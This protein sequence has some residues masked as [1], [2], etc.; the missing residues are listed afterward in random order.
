MSSDGRPG[1]DRPGRG[2]PD[3]PTGGSHVAWS[4]VTYLVSG[5]IAWGGLGW[6]LDRWLDTQV[7]VPIGALVGFAGAF[8]LIIRRHGGG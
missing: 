4:I 8:Y 2:G 1:G 7:F 3:R 6:L 5:V